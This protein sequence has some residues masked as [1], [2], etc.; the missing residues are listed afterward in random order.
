MRERETCFESVM[1]LFFIDLCFASLF[2]TKDCQKSDDF[3]TATTNLCL[4]TSG[5]VF[6]RFLIIS[7]NLEE[8]DWLHVLLCLFRQFQQLGGTTP[9]FIMLF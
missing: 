4:Y 3:C 6:L 5:C 9:F 8:T 7:S 1:V 2:W